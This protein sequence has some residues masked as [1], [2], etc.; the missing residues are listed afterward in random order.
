MNDLFSTSMVCSFVLSQAIAWTYCRTYRGF[1]YSRTFI[2]AMILGSLVVTTIIA[3]IGTNFALGLGVLGALAMIR[4]RT[5]IR[6]PRDII[7]LFSCFGVG[8][9]SGAGA[10][11]VAVIGCVGFIVAAWILYWAPFASMR[12]HD[13]LLRLMAAP[14]APVDEL[15]APIFASTCT[16]WQPA[17]MRDAVQGEAMEWTWQIR[18]RD[19]TAQAHLVAQ[20]NTHTGKLWDA[21][22]L[23]HRAT[24]EI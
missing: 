22:V 11:A 5:Q 13:G 7:F 17:S 2:H 10:F 15:M 12:H 8:I 23:I 4:F 16:A 3:G 21:Q 9:A 14:D 18:L 19:P 1:S 6:D 20:I 24:V